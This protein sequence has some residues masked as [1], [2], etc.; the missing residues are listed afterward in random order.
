MGWCQS[1]RVGT[2]VVALVALLGSGAMAQDESFDIEEKC[3]RDF[4]AGVEYW[5]S[6][7]V[8]DALELFTTVVEAC[9][10]FVEG[11]F[12]KGRCET[13]MQQYA[14]AVKTLKAGNERDPANLGIRELLANALVRSEQ[15]DEGINVYKELI[16]E[17]P[18]DINYWGQLARA[19]YSVDQNPDAIMA[20][21]QAFEIRPD[22]LR[23]I[24]ELN[25]YMAQVPRMRLPRLTVAER[26]LL[27]DPDDEVSMSFVARTY[28]MAKVYSRC[29]PVY[30]RMFELLWPPDGTEGIEY[31]ARRASDMWRY[32]NYLKAI[33][34]FDEATAVMEKVVEHE[35]YAD[36]VGLWI[37]LAFI[38]KDAQDYTKCVTA[39]QRALEIEP[40]NCGAKAALGKGL[41][42]QGIEMEKAGNFDGAAQ[43]YMS[44]K[45]EFESVV[46]NPCTDKWKR[47]VGYCTEEVGRMDDRIK[48]ARARK[49]ASQQ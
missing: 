19:A 29:L 42:G 21:A 39:A 49:V 38:Y 25:S 48:A 27:R 4:R 18:D 37:S 17:N 14:D 23:L 40:A 6:Q 36:D 41:E 22:S 12:Y 2:G 9:P 43:K 8:P 11:Y 24:S 26:L 31:T 13:K 3:N 28:G 10:D 7:Q 16:R 46:A 32:A 1:K 47:Y 30:Q 33:K 45:A 5:R 34:Q 15:F 20:S 35:Q 44:A